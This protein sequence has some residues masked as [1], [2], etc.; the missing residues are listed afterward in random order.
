MGSNIHSKI[1]LNSS[2]SLT[3]INLTDQFEAMS[4]RN[5]PTEATM[6]EIITTTVELRTAS[7]LGQV[8][9]SINSRLLSFINC[10]IRFI[11]LFYNG[12]PGRIRTYNRRS[13]SPLLYQLELLA[14]KLNYFLKLG[15]QLLTT[16]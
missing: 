11:N 15:I 14:L 10:I 13:W 5:K 16:G 2:T 12:E 3:T 1:F 6:I 8:V 9:F 4:M 7:R